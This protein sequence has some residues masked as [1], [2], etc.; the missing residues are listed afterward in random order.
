MNQQKKGKLIIAS[1][2]IFFIAI[3]IIAIIFYIVDSRKTATLHT[4]IAPSYAKIIINDKTYPVNRDIRFEPGEYTVTIKADEF[5]AQEQEITLE[6]HHATTLALYLD[7]DSGDTFT[8][9]ETHDTEYSY[10]LSA[11]NYLANES[12]ADYAAKHPVATV[13]PFTVV[14]VDPITYDWT[15]YAVDGGNFEGCNSDFCIKIT[16][17]TGGNRE[18]A[19]QKIREK[20]FNPNDY[21]IIYEYTPIA[22]LE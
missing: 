1:G 10:Y 17:T 3:V 6:N 20:G 18:K 2:I 15:E 13:L 19:L 11:A 4:I 21:Q 9:Y 12:A 22:P 7:P 16:D 14:E 5:E 8:W